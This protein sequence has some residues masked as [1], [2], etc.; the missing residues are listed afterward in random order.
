MEYMKVSPAIAL[1][2]I[3]ELL[4]SVRDVGGTFICI[5]HN[6]TISDDGIYKGWKE[7]H[8]KMIEKISGIS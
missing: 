4:Q 1:S 2:N 3:Y 5:W 8:D 7:V 6:N